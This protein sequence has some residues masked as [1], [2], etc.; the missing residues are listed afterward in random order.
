MQLDF[1][2][3]MSV[4]LRDENV[5]VSDEISQRLPIS[6]RIGL[7]SVVFGFVFGI[8]LGVLAAVYQNSAIDY[9]STFF[10]VLGQSIPNIVLAPVLIIIFSVELDLLPPPEREVWSKPF[11]NRDHLV[12]L[13]LP[14]VALGTGM[15]AGIARLTRASLLQV[16][17]EDYIRTAR[18]KGLRER[19]VVY[20]HA[21]KNSLIPVAT[22]LG[23][24]LAAILTGTF[25]VE[26]IFLIPGLGKTFIDGVSSRDYTTIMA[27]TLLYSVFLIAGN[28]L[29]DIIYTWLDPRIRF[30]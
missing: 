8:P 3:S 13:I 17:N 12:A 26:L 24:L 21:L 18:A 1:G 9:L 14:T 11:L 16:L 5:Q 20:L 6:M 22:I 10:A 30:D 19:T 23:P 7:V 4:A 25:V 29:V 15:S 27:V 2:P 28:I